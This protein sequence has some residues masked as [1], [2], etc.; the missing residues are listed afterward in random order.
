MPMVIPKGLDK[1]TDFNQIWHDYY[2]IICKIHKVKF[3]ILIFL[4]LYLYEVKSSLLFP[5]IFE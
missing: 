5:I 1:K 2:V 3:K 4:T